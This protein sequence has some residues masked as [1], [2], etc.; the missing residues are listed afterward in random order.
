MPFGA[1]FVVAFVVF[2]AFLGSDIEDD[3]LAV[4][5][6]SFGFRVLSEATD[7]DDYKHPL[8]PVTTL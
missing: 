1:V 7:E 5:V 2:P 4:I 6:S 3:V 8:R